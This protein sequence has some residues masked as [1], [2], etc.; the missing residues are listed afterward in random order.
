[1]R[2][3]RVYLDLTLQSGDLITLTPEISHYLSQ[4]LRLKSGDFLRPFNA[5]D[6]EYLA[7]IDKSDRK[8]TSIIIGEN[9]RPAC[10][11]KLSVHLGL[12]L[13]RGDRMDLAIQKS[14]ELGVASITPLYTQYSEV[15]FKQADRAGKKIDHWRKIAI[16]AA[17]QSGRLTP[18]FV[19]Q[20]TAVAQWLESAQSSLKLIL[21]P[22]GS[23]R[24][25]EL[26]YG[27]S[28]DL[29]IGSEGGFSPEEIKLSKKSSFVEVTMGQ[30][31]MR[32]ETAPIAALAILQ[33]RFG[34]I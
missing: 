33:Y 2:Q 15:K 23:T 22:E 9:Q 24:F 20:P 1:M 18:P 17:E 31:V 27:D 32:T 14:T 29:L 11:A 4:V 7:S 5:I 34:D 6:G 26:P 12:G 13:S 25:A 19:H 10:L 3:P 28:C 30:R 21:T 8:H 16:S